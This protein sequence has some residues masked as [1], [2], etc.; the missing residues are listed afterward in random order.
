MLACCSLLR[1]LPLPV[2]GAVWRLTGSAA[3]GANEAVAGPLGTVSILAMCDGNACNWENM[4]RTAEPIIR[5]VDARRGRE[6]CARWR[7]FAQNRL[8]SGSKLPTPF[9]L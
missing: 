4:G 2:R 6:P 5:R 1:A 9:R 7:R 8:A 3:N